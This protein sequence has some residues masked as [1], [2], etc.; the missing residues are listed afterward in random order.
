MRT[1]PRKPQ[2]FVRISLL[3]GLLSGLS[4]GF[5][6][7]ET[8]WVRDAAGQGQLPV[9]PY[10]RVA[11]PSTT[12][13]PGWT[14][15]ADPLSPYQT[16]PTE[17]LYRISGYERRE[18]ALTR[19]EDIRALLGPAGYR[20]YVA[21]RALLVVGGVA[22]FAG[23]MALLATLG[24]MAQGSNF[25]TESLGIYAKN[26]KSYVYGFSGLFAAGGGIL[27]TGLILSL[28]LPPRKRTLLIPHLQIAPTPR[29]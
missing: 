17:P 10:G 6:A 23:S 8:G 27:I 24:S 26:Y 1:A 20:Q 28:P 2:I 15:P 16:R 4:A 7:T 9:Q 25:G 14:T 5:F 11:L 13:P 21:S 29:F 22:A 12:I 18:E 3:T 19:K